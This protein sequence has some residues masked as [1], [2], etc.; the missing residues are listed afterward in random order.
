MPQ[1]DIIKAMKGK[2]FMTISE[3]AEKV[4]T[5]RTSVQKCID[6]LQKTNEVEFRQ[7]TYKPNKHGSYPY[8]W[9]LK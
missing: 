6:R 9:R 3:I 8:E 4:G 1:S 2:D 5:T 7:K